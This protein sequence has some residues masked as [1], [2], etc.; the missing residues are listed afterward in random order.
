ME[1]RKRKIW[2]IVLAA[3]VAVL[4]LSAAGVAIWY[5]T[6]LLPVNSTSQEVVR[7]NITEGMTASNIAELLEE[8][9]IIR[10]QHA[11]LLYV[12]QHGAHQG[13]KTGAYTVSQSM[14]VAE[15]IERLTSGKSDEMAVQFYTEGTLKGPD[16]RTAEKALKKAGFSDE[17][18]KQA[19]SAEYDNVFLK[20]RPEGASLE[21]YIY[22]ETFFVPADATAQQVIQKNLDHFEAIVKKH[23]L[24][25]RFKE[26]GLTLHEGIILASIVQKESIG[27]G[28][29]AETCEDQQKIAGVFFNRLKQG[30]ALGS[31]VTYHYVADQAG[32][33]RD[34]RLDSPY[35]TR[36]YSGL[37]PGPIASPG[38][39]ALQAVADPAKHDFLY[40]LSGDDDVTYFATTNAGH[41][42][43]IRQHCQ[44]KCLLP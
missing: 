39:S 34:Y 8:R 26:Q 12:K 5:K 33:A 23:N 44:K 41:E 30:M 38:L 14:S 9:Q 10:S 28:A 16:Y 11:F 24:E 1:I 29:S 17:A 32:V 27:C 2:L 21:G 25:Q 4:G 31:D 13:F 37:P 35:N 19:F 40:F 20:S 22:G 43:N 6:N 42:A 7:I 15:I 18:I 3:V 36:I